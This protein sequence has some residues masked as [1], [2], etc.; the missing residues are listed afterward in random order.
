VVSRDEVEWFIANSANR[1][2]LFAMLRQLIDAASMDALFLTKRLYEDDY[3]GFTFAYELKAPAAAAL[4]CWGNRGFDAMV[5]AATQNPSTKNMSLCIDVLAAAAAGESLPP[6]FVPE[7][8]IERTDSFLRSAP[9]LRALARS[10]LVE[11]SLS[12]EDDDD[13][14]SYFGNALLTGWVKRAHGQ[15]ENATT[16]TIFN[17]IAARWLTLSTPLLNEY[18]ALLASH[19][20]DEATFQEFLTAHPQ[21]LDPMAIQIWPKPQLRGAWIPDFVVRRSDGS[22]TVVEIEKPSKL[23]VTQ[24]GQLSADCTQAERQVSDYRTFLTRNF[25]DASRH[26]PHFEEPD[27]LV[28]I[29]LERALSNEQ[30]VILSNANRHRS[31]LRI[32]GFDY[33]LERARTISANLISTGVEVSTLRM[34]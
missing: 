31:G 8:L 14:A 22:Y 10:K 18:D 21:L 24:T 5:E 6:I 28:V 25:A 30:R 27:G 15:R 1:E 32:V 9:E 13:V 4:V 3:G 23:I 11:L 2:A 26:F 17:A 34:A 16:R 12:L 19:A 20:D 33:L 7:W 29:G